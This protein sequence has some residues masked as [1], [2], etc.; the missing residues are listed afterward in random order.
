MGPAV[1]KVVHKFFFQF[2]LERSFVI[3]P[4]H[5]GHE[6]SELLVVLWIAHIGLETSDKVDELAH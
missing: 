4:G 1:L 2:W 6:A 5:S 3:E